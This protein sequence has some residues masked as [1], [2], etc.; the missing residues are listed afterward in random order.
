M[1]EEKQQSMVQV[2]IQTF[3]KKERKDQALVGYLSRLKEEDSP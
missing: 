1:N 3:Q 2:C